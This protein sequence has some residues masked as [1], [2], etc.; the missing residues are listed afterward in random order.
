MRLLQP[1][2]GVRYKGTSRPVEIGCDVGC[3]EPGVLLRAECTSQ[4][5]VEPVET[6]H[7]G[8]NSGAAR[9]MNRQRLG[10]IGITWAYMRRAACNG[11]TSGA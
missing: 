3:G 4:N 7:E 1:P 8:I 10:V 9:D 6:T 11:A 5:T 2:V